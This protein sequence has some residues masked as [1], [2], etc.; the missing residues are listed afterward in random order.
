MVYLEPGITVH[1]IWYYT[2][3]MCFDVYHYDIAVSV[4][5]CTDVSFVGSECRGLSS[6]SLKKLQ[7][8]HRQYYLQ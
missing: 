8:F 2:C 6:M 3:K 4:Y 7:R 1:I 5:G